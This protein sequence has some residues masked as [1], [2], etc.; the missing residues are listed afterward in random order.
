M[1]NAAD[2]AK[3]AASA[4]ADAAAQVAAAAREVAQPDVLRA[5]VK[6][7]AAATADAAKAAASAAG[8]AAAKAA[9]AAREAANSLGEQIKALQ[10][11]DVSANLD[12]FKM[13]VKQSMETLKREFGA[14]DPRSSNKADGDGD[15]NTD[16][17][18]R[19]DSP[20]SRHPQQPQEARDGPSMKESGNR[21]PYTALRELETV[22]AD[23][24]VR[25]LKA[26]DCASLT[27]MTKNMYATLLNTGAA[28]CDGIYA[29]LDEFNGKLPS[30]KVRLCAEHLDPDSPSFAEAAA[31]AEQ[32]HQLN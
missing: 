17:N 30:R 20:G 22:F 24:A 3:A 16:G 8:V 21:C 26:K 31:D 29:L 13:Q 25:V 14:G 9:A 32:V 18:G 11:T 2:A 15:D 27:E 4:A 12:R 1:N 6:N 19:R 23:E 28:S 10:A 7:A 5:R